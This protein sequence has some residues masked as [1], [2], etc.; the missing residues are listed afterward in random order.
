[1]RIPTVLFNSQGLSISHTFSDL[2]LI[3]LTKNTNATHIQ[4]DIII[5]NK[6]LATLVDFS[7]QYR[8]KYITSSIEMNK[9]THILCNS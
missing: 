8:Q 6:I 4:N 2:L 7:S 9:W 3:N 5:A 1:M